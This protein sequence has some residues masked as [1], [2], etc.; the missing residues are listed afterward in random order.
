MS[1]LA[2]LSTA[3]SLPKAS[4][5]TLLISPQKA[6]LWE[7]WD[8]ILNQNEHSGGTFLA[9]SPTCNPHLA[10]LR[11]YKSRILPEFHRAILA[12]LL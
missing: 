11:G 12:Q 8:F 4:V 9:K 7:L 1:E 10:H 5:F 3:Q 2:S 6:A